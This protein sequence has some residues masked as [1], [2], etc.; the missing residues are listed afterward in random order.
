MVLHPT[1]TELLN[2]EGQ[3]N[4]VFNQLLML[5]KLYSKFVNKCVKKMDCLS[6]LEKSL[7]ISLFNAGTFQTT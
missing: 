7:R 5:T 6:S 1:P 4:Q 2:E 3:E